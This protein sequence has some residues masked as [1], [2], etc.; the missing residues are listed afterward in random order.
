MSILG[1][2]PTLPQT[3]ERI[4]ILHIV[5][6]RV[7]VSDTFTT[8]GREGYS[9]TGDEFRGPGARYN[10]KNL[11]PNKP[12]HAAPLGMTP[13][14]FIYAREGDESA[15]AELLAASYREAM[16]ARAREA[17]EVLRDALEPVEVAA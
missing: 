5:G 15:A 13:G 3:G 16:Q 17:L 8:Q 7:E 12:T 11:Y 1:A 6:K 14:G 10:V 4:T 9:L 2:R